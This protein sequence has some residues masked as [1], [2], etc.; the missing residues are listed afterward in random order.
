MIKKILLLGFLGTFLFSFEASAQEFNYNE[1]MK[2]AR[3]IG[4]AEMIRCN[5]TQ[6]LID[7]GIMQDMFDKMANDKD[8]K[9]LS[10]EEL[11]RTYNAFV[12][13]RNNYCKMYAFAQK[14]QFDDDEEF[15]HAKCMQELTRNTYL[16]IN[17]VTNAL[18]ADLE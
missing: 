4:D 15:A 11:K 10:N 1:C 6:T 3:N 8:F 5:Q 16:Y 9:V 2:R 12:T 7:L 17:S 14:G 18:Y 13:Y